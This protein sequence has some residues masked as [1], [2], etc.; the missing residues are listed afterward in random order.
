MAEYLVVVWLATGGNL[1]W[2]ADAAYCDKVLNL[3]QAALATGQSLLLNDQGRSRVV[4]DV[5]CSPK[6][7]GPTS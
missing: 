6:A 2:S 5:R 1:V 4:L 7:S 3:Y